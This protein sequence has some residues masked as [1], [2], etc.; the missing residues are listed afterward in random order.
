MKAKNLLVFVGI[1]LLLVL[2]VNIAANHNVY[3]SGVDWRR[4]VSFVIGV[5]V[6]GSLVGAASGKLLEYIFKGKPGSIRTLLI[7]MCIFIV[8]GILTMVIAMKVMVLLFHWSEPSAEE[9]TM[10]T[11][12]CVLFTLVIGFMGTGQRFLARL[13]QASK[14]KELAQQAMIRSQYEAL[15]NQVNPHFLF[16]S[17]NTLL[18]LI[19]ENPS[20]A[21]Q[22]VE[23]MSKV[24]RYSLQNS[25]ENLIDVAAELQVAES[26]FF[27]NKQRFETKLIINISVSDTAMH[28]KIITHSLLMLAENAI[29][30]NEISMLHPL[31]IDI[32]DGD[33]YLVVKNTLQRRHQLEAS[34]G[35]GLTNIQQ[36]YELAGTTGMAIVE[37]E[38]SFIVKLPL[39]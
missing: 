17:L 38:D 3:A 16:N 32:Y 25:D 1:A 5:T 10:N 2:G 22:F 23:Q 34:T 13:N 11:I 35:L 39:I 20:L 4:S 31:V 26:F 29:K 14:E 19:P 8:Q 18:V 36:R 6:L 9:Y 28:K 12:F 33:N 30:H 27:L 15:K 21:V 24:F 37:T 7:A